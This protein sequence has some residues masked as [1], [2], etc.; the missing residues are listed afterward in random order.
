MAIKD[1]KY[2]NVTPSLGKGKLDAVTAIAVVMT[3]AATVEA[4]EAETEIVLVD[5][6][7][8]GCIV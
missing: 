2:L 4:E 8:E 3:G 7:E 1:F 5:T 6:Q